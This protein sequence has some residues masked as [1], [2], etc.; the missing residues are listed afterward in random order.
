MTF[1]SPFFYSLFVLLAYGCG[2]VYNSSPINSFEK[3]SIERIKVGNSPGSVETGDFNN[4]QFQDLAVTSETDSSVTILLGDGNGNFT[5]S[6]GSPFY[7]GFMPN[8]ISVCDFNKDGYTDLAF[9]NHERKYLT[10]LFGNG[11]GGFPTT[12][13]SFFVVTGVPHTHGLAAGDFNNDGLPDLVTDSWGNNQVEIVYGD[14]VSLFKP[15]TRFFKVGKR[16]YQRLRASDVNKDGIPDIVTTNTESNDVTILLS[17]GENG[18]NEAP[19]SPF[20][21]GDAPFGI[22][23]GDINGDGNQDLVVLNSP[24]SMGEGKGRNGLTVL[25]GNGKGKFTMMTGSPFQAGAIPNRVAIGDLNGD[26][27]NDIVSSDNGSNRI[28]VFLMNSEGLISSEQIVVGRQPKG[29]AIAFLNADRK[30][31][32]I[33]CNQADSEIS[34]IMGK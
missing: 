28:F 6:P 9:A 24:S 25:H 19:G 15:L 5:P 23:I 16:P 10:V 7:A 11:K 20:P 34:I 21:C 26:N 33:I 3:G 22:A 32:I 1:T 27:I 13:R 29:I 2:Q 12:N 30:G 17:E 8:D 14:S 31:D 18:F 4:D